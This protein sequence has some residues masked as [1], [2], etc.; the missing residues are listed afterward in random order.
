MSG[1][2]AVT[3]ATA[4]EFT[5]L[6]DKAKQIGKDTQFTQSEIASAMEELGKNGLSAQQILDG[7]T[8]STAMLAAAAGTTLPTAAVIASDAMNVYNIA[9]K[10]MK[11]VTNSIVGVANASKF[12]VEDFGLALSQG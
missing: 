1:V 2:K 4:D 9:A 11:D 7:A 8:D 10:D 5:A 3:Q 12:S 6:G